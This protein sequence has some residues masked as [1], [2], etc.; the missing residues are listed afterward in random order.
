MTSWAPSCGATSRQTAADP[1][2]I[3]NNRLSISKGDSVLL[4]AHSRN[5]GAATKRNQRAR[6]ILP[7]PIYRAEAACFLKTS[8]VGGEKFRIIHLGYCGPQGSPPRACAEVGEF[9]ASD[10]GIVSAAEAANLNLANTRLVTMSACSTGAGALR[11]GDGVIG[12]KRSFIIAGA[13]NLLL[14]L[15]HIPDGDETVTFFTDFYGRFLDGQSPPAA[16]AS[17]QAE[18]LQQLAEER[19]RVLRGASCGSL[20]AG[21]G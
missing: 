18:R 10:D 11:S 15:W 21:V 9:P 1:V 5:N 4:C 8:A 2:R 20:R 7:S 6:A 17:T 3:R 19:W 13:R 14:T 16:L 12:L